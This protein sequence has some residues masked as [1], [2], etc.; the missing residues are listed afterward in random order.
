MLLN[1]IRLCSCGL[2]SLFGI[3][4][5]LDDTQAQSVQTIRRELLNGS[6]AVLRPVDPTRPG[7]C[8]RN[9]RCITV[10]TSLVPAA[11]L[12]STKSGVMIVNPK[13]QVGCLQKHSCRQTRDGRWV[14]VR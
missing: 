5:T 12:T 9:P 2:M 1:K 6:R 8:L 3:F 11:A 13:L 10:P 14:S 4:V 7:I